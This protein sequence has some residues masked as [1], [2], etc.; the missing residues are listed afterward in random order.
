MTRFVLVSLLALTGCSRSDATPTPVPS[1][2]VSASAISSTPLPSAASSASA[3]VAAPPAASSSEIAY[4]SYKNER[5]CFQLDTPRGMLAEPPPENGDGQS[6]KSTDGA[7]EI[8]AWG[9]NIVVAEQSIDA[10]FADESKDSP[11]KS[12]KV[13]LKA[14]GAGSFV[15]SGYEGGEI[16]YEKYLFAADHYVAFVARYAPSGKAWWD[17]AVERMAASFRAC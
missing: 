12:R 13:T 10:L 14:K 7:A 6:W 17:R 15:V 2:T 4:A 9:A 11:V 1:S 8:K 5:F 3:V 16:F